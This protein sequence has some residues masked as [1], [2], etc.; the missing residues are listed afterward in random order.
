MKPLKGKVAVVTGSDR[1]IG[2]G[3]ADA[4]AKKGADVLI[5]GLTE[6][7]LIE[8]ADSLRLH[9]TKVEYILGD[10]SV[11]NTATAIVKKACDCFGKMDIVVNNAGINIDVI[12]HKMSFDDWQQVIDV[13][14]SAV[15]YLS[16]QAVKY[17][18]EQSSGRIINISSVSWEGNIGQANY[19]AAKAGVIGLSKTIAKENAKKGITCNTICPGF[20]DT[21]MTRGIPTEYW[22]AAVAKI[23]MGYPGK[24]EDI[25]NMV[26]FLAS[27]EAS[28][29]TGE[30]IN[31]GGGYKLG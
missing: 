5:N 11:K 25:G 1:G 31:V 12:F 24:P 28:Y 20:I 18:R 10:V 19:A 16:Q 9:G 26:A 22:E 29:I 3:I 2:Y 14:L 30:V 21:D 15:F 23:P 8:A 17:M 13:N 27:D 4:L 7:L 6:E